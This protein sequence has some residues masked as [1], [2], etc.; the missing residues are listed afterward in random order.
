MIKNNYTGYTLLLI[1]I[2]FFSTY[3]VV[4]KIIGPHIDAFQINFLRFFFG[5]LLLFVFALIKKE[6]RISIKDF[7]LCCVL[8]ILNAVISMG[9]INMSLRVE[10]ASAAVTA[11]LFSCNPIFVSLVASLIDKESMSRRKI[12]ALILG[13]I[14]TLLISFNKLQFNVSSIL[15]PF[16][17]VLS[18]VFF[19]LY[20][21]L[22]KRLSKKIGSLRMNAFSFIGGSL[23]LAVLL[24]I[25]K[26]PVFTF[27]ISITPWVFY[28][29]FFV[30]G[31]AYLFYFAGLSIIGAGK[32]SL[33]FFLKPVF[34]AVL[35]FIFLHERMNLLS[36]LGTVIIL[37]GVW[38]MWGKELI[39]PTN[40]TTSADYTDEEGKKE[41]ECL[42]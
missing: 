15:S 38:I 17:A 41:P 18:A 30:T 34:A 3:E 21:V 35:A 29:A 9:L 4:N 14:G 6:V 25:T 33:V 2:L 31:L 10:N 22:G 26:R 12:I 28:L 27:N 16:L 24:V 13:L 32:G 40:K 8:G 42:P 7:L 20:S 1:T 11:V 37:S 23:I 5:G 19:A 39:F 36:V